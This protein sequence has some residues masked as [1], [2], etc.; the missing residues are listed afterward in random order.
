MTEIFKLK[1]NIGDANI[2]LEGESSLVHTIFAE[3]RDKGLGQISQQSHGNTL[4]NDKENFAPDAKNIEDITI[5][6]EKTEDTTSIKLPNIKD[7]VMKNLPKTEAEWVLIYAFYA[8]GEG[9]NTFTAEDL[10]QMYRETNRHSDTRSKNFSTNFKKAVTS[11]WFAAV[12]SDDDYIISEQG[13][14]FSREI[15]RRDPSKNN[16]VKKNSQQHTKQSYQMIELNLDQKERSEL[17]EYFDSFEKLNGMEKALVLSSWLINHKKIEE[18]NEHVIFSALKTVGHS[19]A[20]DI[21]A[22]LNNGKNKSNYFITSENSGYYK[23]HHLGENHIAE[24]KKDR[25]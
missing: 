12:N 1:I 4:T 20:F 11:N 21:R 17:K 13:K 14:S 19:T 8:S 10:R 5:L 2:E 24:L 16:K 7:V 18:F 23:I 25:G 9:K 6:H 22:A 15:L 3:L